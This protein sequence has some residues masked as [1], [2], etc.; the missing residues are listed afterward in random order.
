LGRPHNGAARHPAR[1]RL[2]KLSAILKNRK[3][4][5]QRCHISPWYGQTD[6]IVEITSGIALWYRAGITPVP[7]RW[8]L[9]R[10][11]RS[12]GILGDRH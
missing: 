9:L 6:R 10:D 11:P 5:W 2:P 1:K 3:V 12:S 7:I 8:V 4:R